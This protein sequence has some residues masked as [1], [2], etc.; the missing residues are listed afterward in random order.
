[1]ADLKRIDELQSNLLSATSDREQAWILELAAIARAYADQPADDIVVKMPPGEVRNYIMVETKG[2][3][4]TDNI[5][6]LSKEGFIPQLSKENLEKF[7]E[8]SRKRKEI[9]DNPIHSNGEP[10][11]IEQKYPEDMTRMLAI[12]DCCDARVRILG[13]FLTERFVFCVNALAGIPDAELG[14]VK[15]A[16]VAMKIIRAFGII[17]GN[18]L[19]LGYREGNGFQED[20]IIPVHLTVESILSAARGLVARGCTNRELR[21]LVKM[22][23]EA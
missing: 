23:E 7:E 4:M 11:R 2:E 8:L 17:D 13:N 15:Q 6:R 9:T 5:P 22:V 14:E 12:V 1:M 19:C 20:D 16:Y 3:E 21:R 10:F 18:D